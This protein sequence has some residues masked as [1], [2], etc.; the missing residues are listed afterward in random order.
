MKS[1]LTSSTDFTCEEER[2]SR[3]KAVELF[4]SGLPDTLP[5]GKFSTL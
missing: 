1:G 2:I 5:A 3:K 4:E